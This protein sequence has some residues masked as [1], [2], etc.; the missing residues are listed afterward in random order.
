LGGVYTYAYNEASA[1]R[2]STSNGSDILTSVTYPDNG[3]KVYWYNEQDKTSGADLPH[4]LTGIVDENGS[5]FSSYTYD[6]AGRVI[7]TEHAGGAQRATF[8]YAQNPGATTYID[9]AGTKRTDRFVQLNNTWVN[10]GQDQPGGSG[11]A[12]STNAASYDANGN[13]ISRTDFDGLVTKYLY[14]QTRNL[15]ISREE[16]YGTDQARTYLTEWSDA[17]RL[18]LRESRPLMR[19]TYTYDA[20][21]N[22]LTRTK[23]ATADVS[24]KQGFGASLTGPA[25]NWT[26]TY[27]SVGKILSESVPGTDPNAR[28]TY[29]YD[30]SNNVSSV[31]NAAG[32]V[33]T[34]NLYDAG[35][36]LLM[37]TDPKGVV[38]EMGYTPRGWV[39][40]VKTTAPGLSP[41]TTTYTYDQ[42]GQ[43]TAPP[44]PWQAPAT[45]WASAPPATGC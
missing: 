6:A 25:L 18:P 22:L 20:A 13:V 10:T 5:R 23:Q 27:N 16:G 12:A 29:T 21:G 15:E 7:S 41:L 24:G 42:V 45:R 44:P 2:T 30:A 14:D 11:C 31:T 32:H 38:T 33:T 36:S 40:T 3:R 39:W 19:I 28:T 1:V 26:Y 34:Y 43:V 17:Y 4:A 37:M 9:P 8:D 35:G